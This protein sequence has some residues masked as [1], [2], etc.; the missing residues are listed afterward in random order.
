MQDQSK[1]EVNR[2]RIFLARSL[3][4]LCLFVFQFADDQDPNFD[5]VRSCVDLDTGTRGSKFQSG[6]VSEMKPTRSKT[7]QCE[8]TGKTVDTE[9]GRRCQ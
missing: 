4:L 9:C 2:E 8:L 7:C 1:L 3:Q 5:A 6:M